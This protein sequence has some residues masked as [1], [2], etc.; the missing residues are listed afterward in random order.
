MN[1][2]LNCFFDALKRNTIIAQGQLCVVETIVPSLLQQKRRKVA[3]GIE[4]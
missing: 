4:K 1:F 3:T 2:V